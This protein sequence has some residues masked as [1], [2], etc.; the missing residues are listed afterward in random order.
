[1]TTVQRLREATRS[2][3]LAGLAM[4]PAAAIFR[5]RG[6]RVNEY[7]RKTLELLVGEVAP[8]FDLALSFAQHLVI[9]V[10]AALPLLLLFERFFAW[11]V[12]W[13]AERRTRALIG[14]AYGAGFYVA[15]NSLALPIAFG[16]PTPWTLGFE[17]VYP[18]LT[19]HLI[20]GAVLGGT[21]RAVPRALAPAAAVPG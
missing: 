6:L 1:M 18:S 11:K 16:D 5:T 8:P 7:G 9:S 15:M 12:E 13:R 3:T 17:T 21:A 4:I 14:T 20:Y 2:G 10:L 19:I